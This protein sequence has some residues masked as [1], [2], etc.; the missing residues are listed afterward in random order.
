M[1]NRTKITIAVAAQRTGLSPRTVR[2][3]IRRGLIGETLTEDELF[4]LRPYVV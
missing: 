1:T 4:V 3:Y 2:R